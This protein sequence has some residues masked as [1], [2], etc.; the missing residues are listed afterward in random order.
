MAIMLTLPAIC[1]RSV[2]L[3]NL[4][5]LCAL[6]AA[7]GAS[8][9]AAAAP[10]P[11][12]VTENFAGALNT[13]GAVTFT[14][15]VTAP[16]TVTASLTSLSPIATLAVGLSIGT[17]DGSV[18]SASLSN[19]N[20]RVSD[21]LTGN[22]SLTGSYCVRVYDVGNVTQTEQVAVTVTHP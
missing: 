19:D 6:T 9:E 18:C 15:T 2:T 1:R 5:V 14:F 12:P 4:A 17:W 13:N 20:T 8:Q 16:G 22:T 21:V 11:T 10:T 7:C 3:L